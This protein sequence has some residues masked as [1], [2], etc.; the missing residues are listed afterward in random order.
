MNEIIKKALEK[1]DLIK[2]SVAIIALLLFSFMTYALI[3]VPIPENNKDALYILLGQLSG[4]VSLIG[5]FYYG[6][7][8]GSQKK[9][10]I[11]ESMNDNKNKP[12]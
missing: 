3:Y 6:S 5:G 4:L 11:I 7:S 1:I 12:E 9:D 8:K 10:G 2:S